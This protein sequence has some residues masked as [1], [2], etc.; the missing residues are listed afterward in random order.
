MKM[1]TLDNGNTWVDIHKI[2]SIESRVYT[3][4]LSRKEKKAGVTQKDK[5]N[6]YVGVTFVDGGYKD[7]IF[8]G[9]GEKG[10]IKAKE[11]MNNILEEIG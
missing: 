4:Y 3:E 10:K 7:G 6:H 1:M 2:L 8:L 5:T 11:I 9:R